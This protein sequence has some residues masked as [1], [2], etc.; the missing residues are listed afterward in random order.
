[1]EEC[2]TDTTTKSSF[3]VAEEVYCGVETKKQPVCKVCG[4]FA[5]GK[6]YGVLSCEGNLI[7]LDDTD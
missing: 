7:G 4:D 6:H 5:T 1:M 3:E 2:V